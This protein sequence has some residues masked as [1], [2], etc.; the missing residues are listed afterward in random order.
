LGFITLTFSEPVSN[1][2]LS[3]L[4]LGGF[5]SYDNSRAL[6]SWAELEFVPED[7]EGA[8]GITRL[9]GTTGFVIDGNSITVDGDLPS[10]N[11]VT[12]PTYDNGTTTPAGCGSIVVNGASVEKIVFRTY[13]R[14]TGGF[15]LRTNPQPEVGGVD[16]GITYLY[17]DSDG[18]VF[19]KSANRPFIDGWSLAV[20]IGHT[21]PTVMANP[22]TQTI[23]A[24][25]PYSGTAVV[26]G[27]TE[28]ATYKV[29]SEPSHGTVV[30]QADGSFVYTPNPGFTGTDEFVYELCDPV[31]SICDAST[32]TLIVVRPVPVPTLPFYGFF[33]LVGLLGLF[34]ARELKKLHVGV[35]VN[36]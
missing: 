23:P 18:V 3:F 10:A 22:Q 36:R 12:T 8:E 26:A 32:I 33:A 31:A 29:V 35:L 9:T 7:S 27:N 6:A 16:D 17:E 19:N 28:N 4:G 11:C 25:Q 20:S 21:I 2:V 1:P 13:L 15:V 34:G 30:M 14:S 5:S 24:D